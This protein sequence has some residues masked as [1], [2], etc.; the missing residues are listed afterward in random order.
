MSNK[1]IVCLGGGS[2]YFTRVL[3]DIL[4]SQDLVGS[5]IVLYDIDAEKVEKMAHLGRRLAEVAGTDFRVRSTVDLIDAVDGAD[6]ALSSIGGSGAEMSPDVYTSYRHSLDMYIPAKYGIHQVVGDTG[7]PAALMMGLR[8]L[9]VLIPICRE[10]ERRSPDVILFNH[11]N[12]MAVLCRAIRKYTSLNV[13]GICHGV[14]IGICSVAEVLDVDPRQLEC[15]WIGTNHYLWFIKIRYQGRDLYPEL[16]RRMKERPMATGRELSTHLSQIYGYQIVYPEDDHIWEFYPFATTVVNPTSM[17]YGLQE[18]AKRFGYDPSKS[19]GKTPTY[20]S[21]LRQEFLNK[22][23]AILDDVTLPERREDG[24]TGEGIGML[25]SAIA[26]GRREVA[27]VNIP[28]EGIISNLSSTGIVEVEGVTDSEG[29]CG[30][31]V[32]EAP[33]HL[34]GILEKRFAWQELVADAGVTGDRN[35][36]LQALLLDEMAILPERTGEMLNEMLAASRD[37][38]PQFFEDDWAL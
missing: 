6:F 1:K 19:M 8:S 20:T 31:H 28:N 12:P 5:E 29:V 24:I 26:H 34:K 37:L 33:L 7:G 11:S 14:Q 30:I 17:P 18:A 36:A 35:L 2:L 13:I 38:L 3:P 9:A 21:S 32:G 25:I 23:Q 22:Y 15:T 27:I 4:L 10:M 16:M